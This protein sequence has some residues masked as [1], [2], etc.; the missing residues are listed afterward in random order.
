M[1]FLPASPPLPPTAPLFSTSTSTPP[2]HPYPP[3]TS[4]KSNPTSIQHPRASLA[5]SSP[6]KKSINRGRPLRT[7]ASLPNLR[8]GAFACAAAERTE[9]SGSEWGTV[10]GS[11]SE[12]GSGSGREDEEGEVCESPRELGTE[13]VADGGAGED[14]GE[15]DT[16][17]ETIVVPGR[18]DEEVEANTSGETVVEANRAMD[19]ADKSREEEKLEGTPVAADVGASLLDA[20]RAAEVDSPHGQEGPESTGENSPSVSAHV[21][22]ADS[23]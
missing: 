7:K 20:L 21:L 23:G 1:L 8:Q 2:T 17:G 22:A 15:G 11:S 4:S 10:L 19:W 9:G 18:E 13:G 12:S 6:T 14:G 5:R 3:R 16:S